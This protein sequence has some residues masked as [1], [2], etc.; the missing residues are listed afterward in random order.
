MFYVRYLLI[1]LFFFSYLYARERSYPLVCHAGGDMIVSLNLVPVDGK[2]RLFIIAKPSSKA[3][4]EQPVALGYCAWLD[5]G[6]RKGEVNPEGKIAIHIVLNEKPINTIR[7]AGKGIGTI[8]YNPNKAAQKEV[9]LIKTIR[10]GSTFYLYVRRIN[11]GV[12]F[13]TRIGP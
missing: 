7:I 3:L 8:S 2:E 6:F 5:R 11:K 1:F 10:R 4:S 9:N 12:F 13:A